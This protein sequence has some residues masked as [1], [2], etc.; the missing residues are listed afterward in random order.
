MELEQILKE[1]IAGKTVSSESQNTNPGNEH[2]EEVIEGE[3]QD[4]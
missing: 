3:F 1:Y 4:V 2:D